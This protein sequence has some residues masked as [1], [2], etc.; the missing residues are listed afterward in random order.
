MV[1]AGLIYRE[2]K[3]LICQRQK[4]AAFPLKWEFPGGKIETGETP[5][6]ALRRELKE[7]LDIDVHDAIE[8]YRHEHVY[9][10][11]PRVWLIFFSVREF[12]GNPK[13]L[14]FEQI[15]WSDLSELVHFDFL[16]GDEPLIRRLVSDGGTGLLF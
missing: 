8:I 13:N 9:D 2:G 12:A 4:S 10:H 14:V 7:E 5:V 16:A 3:L 6:G 15:C 1:V 11:G